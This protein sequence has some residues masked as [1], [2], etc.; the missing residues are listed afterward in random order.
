MPRIPGLRRF[1]RHGASRPDADA[2]AIDDEL[3]FHIETRVDA[4]TAAGM[5]PGD[6]RATALREFGDV[7]R[8][9]D[10]VMTIDHQYAREMHMRELLESVANDLRYVL[11]S[12]VRAPAFFIVAAFTLALGIGA[13]TAI[14]SVVNGVVLQPL[15]YPGSE[16]IVQLFQ[17]DKDGN[18]ASVSEPNF[19]D[20]RE[21]TRAFEAMAAWRSGMITLTGMSEPARVLA[22][23]V[24][25]EF[26]DVLGVK[27]QIGRTFRDDELN[28]SAAPT[29]L[30]SYSFW[31][32]R[33]GGT[34]PIGKTFRIGA[35]LV[36]IVGVMPATVNYPAGTEVWMPHELDKPNPSRTSH[37]WRVVAR[38]KDAVSVEQARQDLSAVSKR[39]KQQYGDETWMFDATLTTLHEQLVGKVRTT[40]FV[41]L[42]ASVF[43][44]LIACANVVNLLVARMSVRR[45]EVGVRL[46]L[47]ASRARLARQFL[48][49]ASVLSITGALG[50]VLLAAGGVKLLVAIQAGKLPRANEISVNWPVLAFAL[51]MGIVASVALGLFTAWQATGGD[52]RS[53][54]SASQRTQAGT[55]S[56]AGLR[57]SLVVT[58]MALTVVLLVGAGLLIRSFVRLTQINPGYRTHQAV[59]LT[60]Q[61]PVSWNAEGMQRRTTFYRDVMT[62]LK[63]VPGVQGV[64]A[65]TGVPLAGGGSDGAYI[66]MTRADE[67][68]NMSDIPRLLRDKTRSGYASYMVVDGDYF[69]AMGIPIVAGRTFGSGDTPDA[70][71][72]AVVSASLAREKWPNES[73]I[74]KIIQ[75]GNMDGNMRPF[76]VVG[77]VGD[78]RD[79]NL[80]VEPSPTFYAYLPQRLASTGDLHVVIQASGDPTAIIASARTI[81][82]DLQPDVSPTIR[83][84]ETLI[85]TSVADRRFVLLLVTVFGS[86]ALILATLGVYSVISY[87]VAQR[88]R[89]IGVRIALGAQRGDVLSLVLRQGASLALIGIA[90]GAIGALF[91]TRLLKGLVF[92][93]STTDPIAFVGVVVLLAAVALIASW[94]PAQRATKVDPMNVLRGA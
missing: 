71:H 15:P 31:Q 64:G 21:Q 79:Q 70:P 35:S 47:G 61:L 80:A 16:R 29:A 55:G 22:A 86:A 20:W 57:R 14:F 63:A 82:R 72:V 37:G 42:G 93:V 25:R 46:A 65:S 81:V 9:H 39:L 30:V 68:V 51:A 74:G 1:F 40:L 60:A 8:Y 58:Q 2:G 88:R 75:Y 66:I 50:G 54:L 59:V 94:M 90:V 77:V 13:T 76:T 84:I 17:I 3:R 6:A 53:V 49:E 23:S 67:P 78:V 28:P 45:D 73:A 27:P 91:L 7:A 41:L 4:L 36:T 89:E 34:N 10:D 56:G 26:V 62:R 87:L 19:A 11:R 5:S 33:M 43:L 44:L 85:A 12:L 52:I 38:V 48:T 24:T 18:R 69:S 83:T 92:G 32:Q